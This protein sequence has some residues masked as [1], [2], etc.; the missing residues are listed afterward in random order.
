MISS[1][2]RGRK[3]EEKGEKK[4]EETEEEKGEEREAREEREKKGRNRRKRNLLKM[5]SIYF[6][7]ITIKTYV[8]G[9]YAPWLHLSSVNKK[10]IRNMSC[11]SLH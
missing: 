4:R 1:I 11:S 8:D 2:A 7:N 3:R 5:I 9:K 6:C 10:N